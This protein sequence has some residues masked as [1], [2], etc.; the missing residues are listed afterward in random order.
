MYKTIYNSQIDTKQIN[1]SGM[2]M[3]QC[4]CHCSFSRGECFSLF[5]FLSTAQLPH[6][7]TYERYDVSGNECS[8]MVL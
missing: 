1:S 6:Q 5:P 4:V 2:C 3:I 8:I 7:L